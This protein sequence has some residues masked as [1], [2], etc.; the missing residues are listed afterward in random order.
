METVYIA[1][2]AS[3]AA[4]EELIDVFGEDAAF[5]AGAR[6]AQSRDRGNVVQFCHWRQIE[7]VI[8]ALCS[9]EVSGTVH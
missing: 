5:E 8:D 7:R 6:A 9:D 3:L 2:R 1:D 4:A